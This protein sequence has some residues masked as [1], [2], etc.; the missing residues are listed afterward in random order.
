VTEAYTC[1][2][3]PGRP[4]GRLVVTDK[5]LAD[6]IHVD[7]TNEHAACAAY[8]PSVPACSMLYVGVLQRSLYVCQ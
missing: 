6:L 7:Y 4:P 8:S 2:C 5:V 1:Y 3:P